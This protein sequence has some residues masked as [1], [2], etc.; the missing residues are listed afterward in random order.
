[1]GNVFCKQKKK[2]TDKLIAD[3]VS[4]V[5]RHGNISANMIEKQVYEKFIRFVLECMSL[6]V[7]KVKLEA[8]GYTVTLSKNEVEE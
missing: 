7:S 5:L 8:L 6:L 1:M 4:G 3:F 2:K